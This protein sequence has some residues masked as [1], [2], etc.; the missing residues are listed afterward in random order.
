MLRLLALAWMGGVLGFRTHEQLSMG[1]RADEAT[2]LLQLSVGGGSTTPAALFN[3]EKK[4]N[5]P[6]ALSFSNPKGN[7]EMGLL[8]AGSFDLAYNG[9]KVYSFVNE[10]TN[11]KLSSLNL[12]NLDLDTMQSAT[13]ARSNFIRKDEFF[14]TSSFQNGWNSNTFTT[15]YG[16]AVLLRA[17]AKPSLIKNYNFT[18]IKLKPPARIIF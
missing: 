14:N 17:N 2:S 6:A 11:I 5:K 16:E 18:D 4:V 1:C 10:T 8:G 3:L 7:F 12:T 13:G 9:E 15:C